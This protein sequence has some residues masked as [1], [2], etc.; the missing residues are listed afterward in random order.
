MMEK[1]RP[2]RHGHLK[3][4][5]GNLRKS[6]QPDPAERPAAGGGSA[7][8]IAGFIP[9]GVRFFPDGGLFS[10]PIFSLPDKNLLMGRR[11]SEC[12]AF[13][14]PDIFSRPDQPAESTD[15]PRKKAKT[16]AGGF[17]QKGGQRDLKE[18]RPSSPGSRTVR[19][20]RKRRG[21]PDRFPPP[22]RQG[23]GG[24]PDRFAGFNRCRFG[25]LDSA[26]LKISIRPGC[27]PFHRAPGNRRRCPACRG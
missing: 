26:T 23:P 8:R 15:G 17:T 4:P 5:P 21:V 2:L 11:S 1:D 14:V 12:R 6:R 16:A 10:R 7:G 25:I 27:S 18:R 9:A 19:S 20:R 13:P 24:R 3:K 22:R